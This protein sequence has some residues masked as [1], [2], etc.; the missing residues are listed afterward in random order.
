MTENTNGKSFIG[1]GVVAAVASSLCCIAPILAIVSGTTG[2]ASSFSWLA[3][4]RPY[5]IGT[6]ALSLGLAFW[7][8]Y[9]KPKVVDDC[10]CEI[11]SKQSFLSS[12]KFLWLV[13]FISIALFSFPYYSGTLMDSKNA[14]VNV[15]IPSSAGSLALNIEGMTCEACTHHVEQ[16][17]EG[18]GGIFSVVADYESGSAS[19]LFDT[20]V[21]SSQLIVQTIESKTGYTVVNRKLQ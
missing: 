20:T 11:E 9:R 5:L 7:Y 2:A 12:K 13:T 18:Q 8:A 3:P 10:G 15:E 19:V 14:D 1:A 4:L 6:S 17:L 16:A 21:I